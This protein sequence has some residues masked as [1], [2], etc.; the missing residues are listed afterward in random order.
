MDGKTGTTFQRDNE[1]RAILQEVFAKWKK[2]K[3]ESALAV[4]TCSN[5][6][7]SLSM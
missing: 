6:R 3:R 4:S 2:R 7:G 5:A 1:K